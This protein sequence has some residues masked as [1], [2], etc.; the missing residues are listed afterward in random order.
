LDEIF[1]QSLDS[2]SIHEL[3]YCP[4]SIENHCDLEKKIACPKYSHQELSRFRLVGGSKLLGLK[5]KAFQDS[6]MNM[7]GFFT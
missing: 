7:K 4:L 3:V 5:V 1:F 2:L 6:H